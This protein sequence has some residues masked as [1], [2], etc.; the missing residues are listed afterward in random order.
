MLPAARRKATAAVLCEPLDMPLHD[1]FE[2][3]GILFQD[4]LTSLPS[5]QSFHCGLKRTEAPEVRMPMIYRLLINNV[6]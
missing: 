4:S 2:M 5:W 1:A 3:T 6:G